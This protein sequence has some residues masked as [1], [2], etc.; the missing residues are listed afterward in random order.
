M[1]SSRRK[2]CEFPLKAS[3]ALMTRNGSR[4]RNS[5]LH[6]QSK[7][8]LTHRGAVGD[9][10]D[11]SGSSLAIDFLAI[12][13]RVGQ[14]QIDPVEYVGGNSSKLQRE[15]LRQDY[16]LQKGGVGIEERGPAH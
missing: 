6:S 10:R 2:L 13:A 9:V 11:Y 16:T 4:K 15:A 1:S 7:L 3:V 14:S 8:E 5:K 12:D